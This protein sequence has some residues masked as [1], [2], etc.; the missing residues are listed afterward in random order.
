[1]NFLLCPRNKEF[2]V[3]QLALHQQLL[4]LQIELAAMKQLYDSLLE[5]VSQQNGFIQQRSDLQKTLKS[6][7]GSR[8]SKK[9]ETW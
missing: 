7:D 9:I 1:M 4:V 5:Q 6:E 8:G 3:Q 2:E